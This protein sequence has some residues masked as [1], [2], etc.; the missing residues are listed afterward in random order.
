[1]EQARRDRARKPDAERVAAQE[2]PRS[3]L[4][5]QAPDRAL[6][7]TK[8]MDKARDVVRHEVSGAA[9]DRAEVR[10]ADVDAARTHRTA[11]GVPQIRKKGTEQCQ[12][13]MEQAR[14]D[15]AQ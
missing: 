2:I 9:R 4:L 5:T 14:W 3:G 13:A 7:T 12:E 15:R 6:R 11:C 10:G 8:V 1:M